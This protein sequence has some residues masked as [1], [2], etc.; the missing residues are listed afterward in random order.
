MVYERCVKGKL[1]CAAKQGVP[2]C[3]ANIQRYLP[4]LPA[5]DTLLCSMHIKDEL[6]R[7]GFHVQV[8]PPNNLL[9]SWLSSSSPKSKSTHAKTHMIA[10]VPF[11]YTAFKKPNGKKVMFL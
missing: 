5:F 10:D 6:V 9:I 11:D 4:G 8:M 3:V 2:F 7:N 1:Q